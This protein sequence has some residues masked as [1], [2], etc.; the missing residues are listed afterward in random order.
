MSDKADLV[1]ANYI[2]SVTYLKLNVL[3]SI[4]VFIKN[5]IK[6]VRS[7]IIWRCILIIMIIT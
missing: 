6:P 4:L 2:C 1:D 5:C 3:R 7:E